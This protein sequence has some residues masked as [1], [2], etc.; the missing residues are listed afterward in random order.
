MKKTS[1]TEKVTKNIVDHIM[2]Q[3]FEGKLPAGSKLPSERKLAM[4]FGIS[5]SSVR[6]AISILKTM[7]ILEVR[8]RGGTF[9]CGIKPAEGIAYTSINTINDTYKNS[10]IELIEFIRLM[11]NASLP[12]IINRSTEEGIKDVATT[13]ERINASINNGKK[14]GWFEFELFILLTRLSENPFFYQTIINMKRALI[15][16]IQ[17]AKNEIISDDAKKLSYIL[18][19]KEFLSAITTKNYEQM[20]TILENYFNLFAQQIAKKGAS[21]NDYL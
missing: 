9:V 13:L 12:L 1:Q 19:I 6:E 15:K 20:K 5:R 2:S 16:I 8:H 7:G 17:T 4:E 14:G 3:F 18:I 21:S 11:L 10:A